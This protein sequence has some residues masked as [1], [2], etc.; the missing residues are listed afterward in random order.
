MA[1]LTCGERVV[2]CLLGEPVDR[3]PYGVGIGWGPWFETLHRWQRESGDPG[4][5]PHEVLG[6]DASF[7]SPAIHSG[8][9]PPFEHKV[10]EESEEFI[11]FRDGRGITWGLCHITGV[12]ERDQR[13]SILARFD[14]DLSRDVNDPAMKQ[15]DLHRA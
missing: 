3:V 2:R 6:F 5:A 4:L 15:T 9:W 10:L 7:A 1:E 14:C 11:T 12:G 8:L 13:H